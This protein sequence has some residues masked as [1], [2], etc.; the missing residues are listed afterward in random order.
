MLQFFVLSFNVF[1]H[2]L[3]IKLFPYIS[4]GIIARHVNKCRRN[5]SESRYTVVAIKPSKSTEAETLLKSIYGD[6]NVT[7]NSHD[8][9][10]PSWI[11]TGAPIEPTNSLV[12]ARL[13]KSKSPPRP[14]PQPRHTD[15]KDVY[16]AYP[17]ESSDT[18]KTEQF[19]R[20]KIKSGTQIYTL[21]DMDGKEEITAW[22]QLH[23]DPEARKEVE[24]YEG[25]AEMDDEPRIDW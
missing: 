5:P 2:V 23:L 20:S 25:I 19:L 16:I 8:H 13:I 21:R 10:P 3:I 14:Q 24:E 7:R 11:V 6:A 12:V 15:P 18:K 9:K 1:S 22:F 4:Q 17:T